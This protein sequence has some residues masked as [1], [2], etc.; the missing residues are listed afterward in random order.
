MPAVQRSA[1]VMHSAATMFNLVNDVHAYPEFV[2]DCRSSKVI[3]ST[4]EHM[5]AALEVA[6]GGICKWF[7]TKNTIRF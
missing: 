5:V 7:T 2:P 1:L 4:P 3:E 6:K